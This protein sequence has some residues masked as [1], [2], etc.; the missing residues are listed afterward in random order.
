MLS[1]VNHWDDVCDVAEL[2]EAD[3]NLLWRR[4][5]LNSYAFEDLEGDAENFRNI[6]VE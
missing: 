1:I 3:R 4:Q 2:S 6:L 5:F